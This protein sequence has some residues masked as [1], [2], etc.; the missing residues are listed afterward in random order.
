MRVTKAFERR[1]RKARDRDAHGPGVDD[2]VD[3]DDADDA[4]VFRAMDE[5]EHDAAGHGDDDDPEPALDLDDAYDFD[6]IDSLIEELDI[7]KPEDPGG[8]PRG[9]DI[10][11]ITRCDGG[12]G[13][14]PADKD[15]YIIFNLI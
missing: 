8:G 10:D 6:L 7:R 4:E 3:H 9:D 12:G 15:P 2:R 14:F 13:D 1:A 11:E 5:V